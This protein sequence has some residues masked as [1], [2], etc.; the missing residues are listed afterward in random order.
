MINFNDPKNRRTLSAIIILIV[1][2]AMVGTMVIAGFS[3]VA[4]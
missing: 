4:G 3:A 1:I 2:V